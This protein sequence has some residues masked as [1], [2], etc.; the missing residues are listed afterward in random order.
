M[1]V[2]GGRKDEDRL[3]CFF[4]SFIISVPSSCLSTAEK[5][6]APGKESLL[7]IETFASEEG[8]IMKQIN[9]SNINMTLL[10]NQ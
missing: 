4:S 1:E 2:V 8:T 5:F 6:D 3:L 10:E 7:S 9:S